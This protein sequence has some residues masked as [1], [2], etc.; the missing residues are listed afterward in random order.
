[1]HTLPLAVRCG[2]FHSVH[3]A[4]VVVVYMDSAQRTFKELSCDP[5]GF[6]AMCLHVLSL[7]VTWKDAGTFL[8]SDF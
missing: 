5:S 3:V 2:P 1:M 7:L 4:I 6:A 8:P